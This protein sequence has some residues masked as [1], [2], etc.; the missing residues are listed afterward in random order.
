MQKN[1][2][3]KGESVVRDENAGK[4]YPALEQIDPGSKRCSS[5]KRAVF[6]LNR[7][8]R[9]LRPRRLLV[10]A[11]F[12][13]AFPDRPVLLFRRRQTRKLRRTEDRGLF[14]RRTR[15]LL[16]TQVYVRAL[17]CRRLTLL[18][19]HRVGCTPSNGSANTLVNTGPERHFS[20]GN[21]SLPNGRSTY[22]Q[23]FTR[24]TLLPTQTAR[25]QGVQVSVRHFCRHTVLR[26]PS[27]VGP[28]PQ[29]E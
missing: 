22:I 9:K 17:K 11:A 14:C 15:T 26:S 12:T 3:H 27:G 2:T 19:G 20:S 23:P 5:G 7:V 29:T 13:I 18:E 16:Q 1:I 6:H 8:K 10:L 25:C 24:L 4:D 21:P 28:F